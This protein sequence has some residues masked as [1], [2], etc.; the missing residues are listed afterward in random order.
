M[1]TVCKWDYFEISYKVADILNPFINS[2]KKAIFSTEDEQYEVKG[3]YD[4]DDIYTFRFMPQREGKYH[5]EI[6]NA[7]ISGD[8]MCV[9]A[10]PG[11]K[12]MVQVKDNTRLCYQDNT[13]YQSLGT[14][15]YAW[16]HQSEDLQKLTI[17]SLEESPFN[18]IRMCIFPKFFQFNESEPVIYPYERGERKGFDEKL[19]AQ[20]EAYPIPVRCEG[21]PKDIK[22]F[23]YYKPNVDFYKA[24]DKKI[25]KL[26]KLGIEAD[27]ILFHPYDKWGFSSMNDECNRLY[28]KYMVARYSAF[29]NVWWSMANEYE[30]MGWPEEKW[31]AYG[32]LVASEDIYGHMISIHNCFQYYDYKKP[33]ITHCSMQRINLYHHVEETEQKIAEYGKPVVWDE[34]AYEGD[35]DQGWGNISGEELTRRFWE[36]VLRGGYPGH[37]ETYLTEDRILWWSH[38]G[39]LRGESHKRIAFL[40]KIIAEVPGGYLKYADGEAD[41]LVSIPADMEKEVTWFK[42]GFADYELHYLGFGRPCC[43]YFKLPE[44]R[45]Y[46]IDVID[47]W[48]MTIDNKGIF[49][50]DCKVE[51][52]RKE[53]MLIRLVRVD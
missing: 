46:Q 15:C 20:K 48:N 23:N 10:A 34:I 21:V 35:V 36:A 6:L 31:D 4:G 39:V 11:N 44:D 22:N 2:E 32:E 29:S 18:K 33:W 25:L 17:Q 43:R 53:H 50:G 14:T 27:L 30:I 45:K 19:E 47:T 16:I 38:G 26:K 3:F 49:Q 24:L 5:Y 7:D 12:G 42:Q 9:G 41:E 1:N 51:M 37:G 28:L 13:P 8:F 40:K 52:P